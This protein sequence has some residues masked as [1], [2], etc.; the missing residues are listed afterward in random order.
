MTR[1]ANLSSAIAPSRRPCG[2]TGKVRGRPVW[3]VGRY[4]GSRLPSDTNT[5]VDGR[6]T[7]RVWRSPARKERS[8]EAVSSRRPRPSFPPVPR[9]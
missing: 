7:R 5:D 4:D 1:R 2:S 8:W 9:P 3:A 6:S